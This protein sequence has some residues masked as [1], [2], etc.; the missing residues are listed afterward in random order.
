MDSTSGK[1]TVYF[2]D[3]FCIGV[4]E[5]ISDGK[6]TAC[7]VTF[8]ADRRTARFGSSSSGTTTSCGSAPPLKPRRNRLRTTQSADNATPKSSFYLQAP[9]QNLSRRCSCSGSRSKPTAGKPERPG[10]K[11]NSSAAST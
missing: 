5:R 3:P 9:G 2:E 11:P 8:G 7:K 10:G 6:L 1:L 4:F